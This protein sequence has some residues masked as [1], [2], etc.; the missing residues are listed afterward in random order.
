MSDAAPRT[1]LVPLDLTPAGEVKISVVEEYARALRA[2]VVL[3]HVLRP[4]SVAPANVL[5]TE[6]VARTYLDTVGSRLRAAGIHTEAVL[7]TGAAATVIVQEA[8]IH[9]AHLIV[10]GTNTRPMFSTAVLGS[11]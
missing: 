11:I 8:F 6:A 9:N 3:P 5:P 1:I 10:L 4:G 7:R 2:S